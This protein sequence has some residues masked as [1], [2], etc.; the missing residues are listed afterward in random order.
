MS[1]SKG[2]S[3]GWLADEH[4]AEQEVM[5]LA[6]ACWNKY[7]KLPEQHPTDIN[8][9][10]TA[11]HIIQYLLAIRIV[12]RLYPDGWFTKNVNG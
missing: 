4:E 8:E 9:F 7:K 2:W 5:E 6:V 10:C 3:A 11:I 12:Q 1:H